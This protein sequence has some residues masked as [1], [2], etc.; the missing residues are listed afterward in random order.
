LEGIGVGGT[1]EVLPRLGAVKFKRQRFLVEKIEAP[2]RDKKV[3][4]PFVFGPDS[5]I[6]Y[7]NLDA[8]SESTVDSII[9]FDFDEILGL[10]KELEE[11]KFSIRTQDELEAGASTM[12]I[13]L[14]GSAGTGKSTILAQ[15]KKANW[16]KA[17]EIDQRLTNA[18]ENKIISR[19]EEIFKEAR[20]LSPSVIVVDDIN[21]LAPR[22]DPTSFSEAL[23]RLV[24]EA[25]KH[26]IQFVATAVRELDIQSRLCEVFESKIELPLPKVEGRVQ[27][28]NAICQNCDTIVLSHVAKQ[29]HAFSAKDLQTLCKQAANAAKARLEKQRRGSGPS[30]SISSQ[31]T[32]TG[33]QFI[34]EDFEK[35]MLKVHPTTM[36][37]VYVEVPKV[38]WSDIGGSHKTKELLQNTVKNINR[39]C[40][41]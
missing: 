30:R 8:G 7:K 39:V 29:T 4:L 34:Q 24:P 1:F 21:I 33:P 6:K 2:T 10:D 19:L 27:V 9:E 12:P 28:L 25:A 38:H 15:L 14:Y 31:G 11:L 40:A 5:V 35:A 13:L 32:L 17:F 26:R 20:D 16:V 36:S 37:E 22:G 18:G 41:I 23:K 3:M